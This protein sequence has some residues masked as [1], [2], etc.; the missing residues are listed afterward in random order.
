MLGADNL[1]LL[2][3]KLD[4]LNNQSPKEIQRLIDVFSEIY[5]LDEYQEWLNIGQYKPAK[6]LEGRFSLPK[7]FGSSMGDDKWL[8][9]HLGLLNGSLLEV[10]LA[11]HGGRLHITDGSWVNPNYRVYPFTDESSLICDHVLS[12]TNTLPDLMID[13]ASGCG[14]HAL[15]LGDIKMRASLDINLRAIVYSRINTILSGYPQMLCGINDLRNGIPD[16]FHKISVDNTLITINMPFAI[17]PSF[18]NLPKTLAQDGGD[19]GA[20]LTFS[21]LDAVFRMTKSA[22]NMKS[23][24]C[25][26]L[27][28]SLGNPESDTWEVVE[29]ARKLFG[30]KNVKH[31]IFPD[32]KMWRINGKKEQPNPMP[33][34]SLSLKAGCRHTYDESKEREVQAGYEALS[35]HFTKNGFS[36]LGYGLADITCK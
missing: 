7:S 28:Y 16:L 26:I 20:A 27:F 18:N 15:A 36:H 19:R 34:S 5:S 30:K 1:F 6:G 14:H 11:S 25:V 29:R 8:L 9:Q 22:K 2:D 24:R 3:R 21:A 32:E 13:P 23:I 33:V 10:K 12:T 31:K 4:Y 35:N 17:F